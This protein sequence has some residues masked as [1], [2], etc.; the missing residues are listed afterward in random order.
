[1]KFGIAGPIS[2][3]HVILPAGEKLEKYGA[4]AYTASAMGKLA[5]GTADRVVCL[6]HLSAEDF[7]AVASL[8]EHPNISLEGLRAIAGGTT[9]IELRYV[10]E[11][12]RLSRQINI[13][14]P[15]VPA[16]INLLSDCEAVL[17]MPLNE[18]DIA[19]ECVQTLKSSSGG[20]IFLDAH[21]LVTGV[22]NVGCRYRKVWPDSREWFK[23]IDILK[24][25]ENEAPWVAGHPMNS[26][27]E[28][29]RFAAGVVE[30]GLRACWITFG[31][32][33]SLISWRR[34]KHI[35]WAMVPVVTDIGPVL[36]TTGCGDASSAGFVYAYSKFYHNPVG[37]VIMGNTLG[38]F[39]ATFQETN[40][41]P[42]Q[43]EIRGVIGQHYRDYLHRLLD[44]FLVRSHLIVHEIKGGQDIESFMYQPGGSGF[45]PGTDNAR[46]SGGQGAPG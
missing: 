27:E 46:D 26:Y 20:I 12:E 1:M 43:P 40:T 8:L 23:Y 2:R 22:D 25:N 32:R 29:A 18:T 30:S 7:G 14:P 41:F 24:I 34:E 38:S 9:E 36:D 31:D 3:D 5:E 33:S 35:Y 19:L 42:S 10:N 15:V 16:E 39:K 37:A 21:G 4:V 28:Y 44:D 13:M 17:L 6:S 11:K 45:G